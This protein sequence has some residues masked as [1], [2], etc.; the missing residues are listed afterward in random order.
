LSNCASGA[1]ARH[2]AQ[3]CTSNDKAQATLT[4]HQSNQAL[5]LIART[6]QVQG[7]TRQQWQIHLRNRGIKGG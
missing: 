6:Q 3:L 2:S 5:Q 4:L 7:L 1:L